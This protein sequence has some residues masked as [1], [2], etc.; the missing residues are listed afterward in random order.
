MACTCNL[1]C[2]SLAVWNRRLL[3]QVRLSTGP[4]TLAQLR[5]DVL[6]ARIAAHNAG[7]AVFSQELCSDDEQWQYL[8]RRD[9]SALSHVQ[10]LSA[11]SAEG[12]QHAS[13]LAFHS[14]LCRL[15]AKRRSCR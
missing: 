1:Y 12:V 7:D 15:T 5:H 10:S 11:G 2:P 4:L 8:H 13:E 9:A 3:A 14:A 6:V